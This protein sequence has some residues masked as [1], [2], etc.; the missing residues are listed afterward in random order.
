MEPVL[1]SAEAR[2]LL[3][4][5]PPLGV[6]M[7]RYD[8]RSLANV[9]VT[10]ARALG[11]E[12]SGE[13][14]GELP[15][16]D[17][18]LD[19]FGGGR[20]PGPVVLV[21][22]D[23]LGLGALLRAGRAHPGTPIAAWAETARPITSVFPTTTTV[24]LTSLSTASAPSQH[25][26]VGHREYLPRFG[27]VV[28]I[29]RMTPL[30]VSQDNSL[31]GPAWSPSLVAGRPTVF[32]RGVSATAVSRDRFEGTG[33]TRLL[34]DGARYAPYATFAD[35]GRALRAALE[36]AAPD[37]LVVVYWDELD[38]ALH[39]RGP[40]PEITAF[41]VDRLSALFAWVA[42]GLPPARAR[43]ASV[44]LT[45][46]HGLVPAEPSRQLAVEE[47]AGLLELLARPPAG[48]RRSAFFVARSGRSEALRSA[49]AERLP[50]PGRLLEVPSAVEA[51]LFGPPPYHPELLERI[52]EL[53][54]LPDP[55]GGVGYRLPGQRPPRRFLAGAH[56]GLDAEEL[57]VPLVAAS[58]DEL[59]T[60][61]A[62]R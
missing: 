56:G 29:L 4:P 53:L 51:G 13:L 43:S 62:G 41:E 5:R 31:V 33:F 10:A 49:L 38:T 23:G 55:P 19:P 20:A 1:W 44:L 3:E 11:R 58:L 2:E 46:D 14:P 22:V 45:A 7:P 27:S 32:R 47:E 39:V 40:D 18:R 61:G 26:V 17:A 30:G 28:E 60:E 59:A 21:L 42:R 25:G 16:L 24:A 34:Y 9:I 8:G 6:P 57:L 35:M 52:G 12:L 54:V 37:D 36:S 15:A 50:V 48:D